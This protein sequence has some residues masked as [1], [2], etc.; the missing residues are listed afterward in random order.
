MGCKL[1]EGGP[2]KADG[3]EQ[4]EGSLMKSDNDMMRAWQRAEGA[5]AKPRE[6]AGAPAVERRSPQRLLP[7][8]PTH[9]EDISIP[10]AKPNG[11]PPFASTELI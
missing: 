11:T 9:T 8:P 10:T 5:E 7:H 1:D 4:R 2:G 3:C 6:D